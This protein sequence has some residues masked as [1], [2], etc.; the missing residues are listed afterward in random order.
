MNP[1]RIWTVMGLM[2]LIAA[3]AFSQD[4]IP[5]LRYDEP[6]GFYHSA[7]TPPD[8]Y[9][10]SQ[11][12]ASFQV[13]PF[14]PFNGDIGRAFQ[15]TLL[16]DWIDPRYQE[17]NVAG[18]PEFRTGS[19]PGAQLVISAKFAEPN[20]GPPKT[21][22]RYLIVAGGAAA[23]IDLSANDATTWQ[24]FLPLLDPWFATL[25]V[26]SGAAPTRTTQSPSP[27]ERA[28]AG[29]Y[30]A[31]T[32][33]SK[34][35]PV[36]NRMELAA[37]YYVFSQDGRVHRTYDNSPGDPSRF[38]FDAAQRADAV[39]S[40][41]YSVTGNQ[42]RIEMGRQGREVITTSVEGGHFKIGKALYER[43]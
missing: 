27:G 12:N 43:Q 28:M 11:F 42:L 9:S 31:L 25:R 22:I 15:M 17:T 10:A 19:L 35:T 40:G 20:F 30:M 36:G 29:V 3:H 21:R 34:Y 16:R 41:V 5:I 32:Y 33:T 2:A 14:R 26:E 6:N 1:K 39:N 18:R 8:D 7:I 23:L 37:F 4:R 24:R 38:D 13:Y